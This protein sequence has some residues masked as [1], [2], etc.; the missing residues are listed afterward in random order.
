MSSAAAIPHLYRI[1]TA[2]ETAS[3]K[4]RFSLKEFISRIVGYPCKIAC[5]DCDGVAE[6]YVM[7][8]RSGRIEDWIEIHENGSIWPIEEIYQEKRRR[9]R[10]SVGA[11]CSAYNDEHD[12][13][14]PDEEED[15]EED[16][17]EESSSGTGTGDDEEESDEEDEDE[18]EE[19]EDEDEDEDEE[20]NHKESSET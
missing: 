7:S 4:E 1:A 10:D 13:E 16:E 5:K 8:E 11:A 3:D 2:W 17:D 18:D 19:D 6:V 12:L 14:V 20:D 15:D 9:L